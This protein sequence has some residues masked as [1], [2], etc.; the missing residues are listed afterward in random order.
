MEF[1]P[2]GRTLLSE[3][4]D[5][6]RLW[7]VASRSEIAHE[8]S[9][10]NARISSDGRFVAAQRDKS[11]VFWDLASRREIGARITV[12][13]G[14][15]IITAMALSPDGTIVATAGFDNRIRFFD[16][17]SGR[18]RP[19]P[20]FTAHGGFVNDLAFS[21][22]GQLLAVTAYDSSVRL[23][24]VPHRRAVGIGLIAE[25][26]MTTALDFSPDG[27]VLATGLTNGEVQLWD[28][29]TYRRLGPAMKGHTKGVTDLVYS[30]DG[31]TV[32]TAS[33]DRT[34]RLWNVRTPPDL[35]AAAC[36]NAGR[37]LTREEWENLVPQEE[38]RQTCP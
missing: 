22:D 12:R 35:V 6:I 16:V 30:D 11:I 36:A 17:A 38:Y 29:L 33:G 19:G 7:D 5:G 21:P 15:D 28:L 14:T 23:W 18:E 31:T 27:K 1:T 34:A 4:P 13:D 8:K 24:D 20:T 25:E 26:G 32:A 3:G 9:L 2:D 37:S 10:G